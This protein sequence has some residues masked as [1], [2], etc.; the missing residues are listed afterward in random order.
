MT[1]D[2]LNPSDVEWSRN[3]FQIIMD[4]GT[5]AVPRSGLIF[6]KRSTRLELIARM[7]HN[8]DMPLT[9]D[10]LRE[11]QRSEFDRIKSHFEAAGVTVVNACGE[12]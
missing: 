11:Q 10:E 5:W 12:F 3:H 8:P 9:A 7:P 4:G 2:Q 6:Q 1:S